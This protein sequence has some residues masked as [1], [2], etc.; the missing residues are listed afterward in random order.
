MA[1]LQRL[2]LHK[3]FAVV[4][5]V[6]PETTRFELDYTVKLSMYTSALFADPLIIKVK[7]SDLDEC[8]NLPT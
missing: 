1:E 6:Y 7:P 4:V 5:D 2:V 8:T 3:K